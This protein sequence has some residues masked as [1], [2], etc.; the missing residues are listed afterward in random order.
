MP[1]PAR[2]WPPAC[3]L[4]QRVYSVKERANRTRR[5]KAPI[6]Q[7]LGIVAPLFYLSV[8]VFIGILIFSLYDAWQNRVWRGA[9]VTVVVAS[10]SPRVYS[11]NPE[12]QSLTTFEVPKNTQVEASGGYG[13]WLVGNLWDLGKQ[14]KVDTPGQDG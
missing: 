14:E 1:A 4:P 8:L 10:E 6:V 3:R 11:Y 9:R 7:I 12:N 5:G 13:T 2:G